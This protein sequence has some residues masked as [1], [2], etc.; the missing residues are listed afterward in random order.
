MGTLNLTTADNY[1]TVIVNGTTI[2]Q[3]WA[4]QG[5][6]GT[7]VKVYQKWKTTHITQY[8]N[9]LGKTYR[10]GGWGV[11]YKYESGNIHSSS[12]CIYRL[13]TVLNVATHRSPTGR[14]YVAGYFNGSLK[15]TSP[16]WDGVGS[17]LEY[18]DD[19]ETIYSWDSSYDT[20][21]YP[22]YWRLYTSNGSSTDTG[23]GSDSYS[24]TSTVYTPSHT[25]S[26]TGSKAGTSTYVSRDSHQGVDT[27]YDYREEDN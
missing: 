14:A 25:E 15:R 27:S 5:N 12:Y 2:K 9:T 20:K 8:T 1:L 4:K 10:C 26:S 3:L 7:P 13:K 23:Y 6:D 24:T 16:Y 21:S 17:S 11:N 18:L 22:C 19:C